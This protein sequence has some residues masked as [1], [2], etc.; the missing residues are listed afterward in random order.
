[1]RFSE[2]ISKDPA[3]SSTGL[4]LPH[5][6][7]SLF[8]NELDEESTKTKFSMESIFEIQAMLPDLRTGNYLSL[9]PSTL[10]WSAVRQNSLGRQML[11][12]QARRLRRVWTSF[13]SSPASTG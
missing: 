6:R 5:Q 13:S 10:L 12:K 3:I 9:C 8:I 1:M 2:E 11:T 4:Q 7:V